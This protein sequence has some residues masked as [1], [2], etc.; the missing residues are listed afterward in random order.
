MNT[1][2]FYYFL[3]ATF[4]KKRITQYISVYISKSKLF[5]RESWY[6]SHFCF[7]CLSL[8]VSYREFQTEPFS[9][10]WVLSYFLNW[11]TRAIQKNLSPSQKKSEKLESFSSFFLIW[12]LLTSMHLLQQCSRFAIP[13]RE[14][15]VCWPL[16]KLLHS[17]FHQ[18]IISKMWLRRGIEVYVL[19]MII[20][21]LMVRL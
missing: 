3:T 4:K 9:F 15:V 11:Y 7:R 17:I 2:T 19:D 21:N 6:F 13:S 16:K 12:S 1:S 20:N 10:C 14:N 5:I 8:V 18:I